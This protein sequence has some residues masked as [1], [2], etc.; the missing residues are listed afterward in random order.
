MGMSLTNERKGFL[1]KSDGDTAIMNK[2]PAETWVV[3]TPLDLDS[4]IT[5]TEF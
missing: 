1:L 2:L 4:L 5:V 3:S